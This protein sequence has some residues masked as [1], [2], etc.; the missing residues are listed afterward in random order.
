MICLNQEIIEHNMGRRHFP[1]WFHY[2]KKCH[3]ITDNLFMVHKQF[4]T[5]FLGNKPYYNSIT[6]DISWLWIDKE[7]IPYNYSEG[8]PR[9]V[10]LLTQAGL[11]SFQ[12]ETDEY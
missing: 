9:K 6:Q 11:N 1:P 4:L 10:S 3:I 5:S 8:C 2:F 7:D 12:L